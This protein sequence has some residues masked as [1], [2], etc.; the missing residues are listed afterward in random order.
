MLL[1]ELMLNR[2]GVE[3]VYI[4]NPKHIQQYHVE[5]I[6]KHLQLGIEHPSTGKTAIHT[7]W[8]M[9]SILNPL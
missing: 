9:D 6:L 4:E 5:N 3:Q 2:L 7:A 1:K 8:I